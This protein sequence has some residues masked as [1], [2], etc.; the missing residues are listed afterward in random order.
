MVD[1]F[2]YM[3]RFL[4]D[5]LAAYLSSV[6]EALSKEEMSVAFVFRMGGYSVDAAGRL[7][8]G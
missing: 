4:N 3:V 2:V 7:A 5:Q 6:G 8:V 1:V